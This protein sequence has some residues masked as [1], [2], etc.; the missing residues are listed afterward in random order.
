MASSYQTYAPTQNS[1]GPYWS[2]AFGCPTWHMYSHDGTQIL[3]VDANSNVLGFS[4]VVP[5]D[6][7]QQPSFVY[8]QV[9]SYR[10]QQAQQSGNESVVS[11][12]P[13]SDNV[14]QGMYPTPAPAQ[15]TSP[16]APVAPQSMQPAESIYP[17]YPQPGTEAAGQ[18]GNSLLKVNGYTQHWL[19]VNFGEGNLT[20]L[21]KWLETSST[22]ISGN[23]TT[24]MGAVT[25]TS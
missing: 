20:R 6:S 25:S 4:Q 17:S 22:T 3:T 14:G 8:T 16:Y 18:Q 19:Q 21:R 9:G 15:Y 24:K 2:R 23:L 11:E 13:T 12:N 7:F 5:Q 10:A 1:W